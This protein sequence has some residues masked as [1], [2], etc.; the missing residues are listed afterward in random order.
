MPQI[1]PELLNHIVESLGI[2]VF[3]LNKDMEVQL[4]NQFM[5]A[6]SGLSSDDMLGKNIFDQFPELPQRWFK[7]KVDS[8][9]ILKNR[10][11]TAW[12]QRPYLFQFKHNR[13]VTGGVESMYQ[14]CTFIP[15]KDSS[16][17]VELVCIT[18]QDVTDE[19]ISQKMLEETMHRL[20][21][22]S[23]TDGLTQL[24]NRSYWEFCLARECKRSA[25]YGSETSLVMF[26]LDHFKAIND[27]YGHL[28]GDE[29]LREVAEA[30]RQTVRDT[31][32]AGRYGGEEFGVVL[33]DTGL[34]GAKLLA[35]RLRKSIEDLKVCYEN[36]SIPVT[37]SLGVAEYDEGF[38]GHEELIKRSDEALYYSKEHGRNCWASYPLDKD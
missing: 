12:K 31:D 13:P 16:G 9:F 19:G 17:E 37:V 18:M 8:V 20:E 35:E 21:Q 25:R 33:S 24:L 14:N 26:D 6:N 7:K 36:Q 27:N 1:S 23:R 32:V 2:G 34:T 38:S 29:V 15:V 10:S 4:W 28:A 30:I 3:I 5:S 11:F 22:S